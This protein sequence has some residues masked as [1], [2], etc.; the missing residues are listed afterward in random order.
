MSEMEEVTQIEAVGITIHW[1]HAVMR[2]GN[3]RKRWKESVR[4]ESNGFERS[5]IK[6]IW[7]RT[8]AERG[9]SDTAIK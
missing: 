7:L 5:F 6:R 2:G 9:F 1:G 4:A 8:K 3:E